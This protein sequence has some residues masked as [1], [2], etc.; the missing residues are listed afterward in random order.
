MTKIIMKSIAL[1]SMACML[2]VHPATASVQD[3]ENRAVDNPQEAMAFIKDLASRTETV[4]EDSTL[5]RGER[6]FAFKALFEEATNTDLIARAMLGVNY[7]RITAEQRA[8]YNAAIADYII[9][10][11]DSRMTQFGYKTLE[12]VGT[13]PAPGRRGHIVVRTEVTREE[14]EPI[15]LDWRVRKHEGA[16]QIIN[17]TVEGINLVV[18]NRELFTNRI[19]EVGI[20]GLIG[21]LRDRSVT[22]E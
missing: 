14:G 1:L 21:E 22:A 3:G 10:E 19:G 6:E 17:L 8:E 7:R 12:I 2:L 15:T 20:D 5:T 9:T 4:W 13:T 11:F 18:T 16:L